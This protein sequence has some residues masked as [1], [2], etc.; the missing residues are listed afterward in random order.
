MRTEDICYAIDYILIHDQQSRF[1]GRY[2]WQIEYWSK[3]SL[4]KND[5]K[6]RICETFE[7]VLEILRKLEKENKQ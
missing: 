5:T 2:V 3:Y 1:Q 6:S 4:L 7:E